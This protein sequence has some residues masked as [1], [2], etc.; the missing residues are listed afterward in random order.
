[1]LTRSL[2][3]DCKKDGIVVVAV[4][5]CWVQTDMGGDSA[6]ISAKE[7]VRQLVELSRNLSLEQSGLF[8]NRRG[9]RL[10]W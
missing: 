6:A 2:A 3:A 5:P 4:C 1:M 10:D 8:L 7:S 9:E